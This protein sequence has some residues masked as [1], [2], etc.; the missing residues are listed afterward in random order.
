MR[1]PFVH[2]DLTEDVAA[3]E[4]VIREPFRAVEMREVR[5]GFVGE[6]CQGGSFDRGDGVG[7]DVPEMALFVGE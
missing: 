4:A 1:L 3:A 6:G 5:H 2:G 7:R